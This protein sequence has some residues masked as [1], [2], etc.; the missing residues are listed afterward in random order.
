M[1]VRDVSTELRSRS[2]LK[3]K[4]SVNLEKKKEKYVK[5]ENKK[6]GVRTIKSLQE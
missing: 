5:Y 6:K 1:K 4:I 3:V 2:I